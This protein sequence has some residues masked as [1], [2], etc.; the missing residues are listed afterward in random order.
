MARLAPSVL[1]ADFA[2]LAEQ[3]RA[4]EEAGADLIHVDVM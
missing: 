4:C 3:L 1:S 2:R